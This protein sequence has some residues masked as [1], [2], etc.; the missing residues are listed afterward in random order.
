MLIELIRV[1]ERSRAQVRQ[2]F[3][4]DFPQ[5]TP[6][7]LVPGVTGPQELNHP[8]TE[9]TA[10]YHSHLLWRPDIFQAF[11]SNDISFFSPSLTVCNSDI[12]PSNPK[13]PKVCAG[14]TSFLVQDH[15]TSD[16]VLVNFLALNFFS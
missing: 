4:L 13:A 10:A 14:H 2:L 16:P 11:L 3:C 9:G 7:Q 6:E 5:G 8:A 1:F 12:V 15:R